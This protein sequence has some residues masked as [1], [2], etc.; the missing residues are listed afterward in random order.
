MKK[1]F[2]KQREI[3]TIIAYFGVV[4]LLVSRRKI[5][6]FLIFKADPAL[7]S[8]FIKNLIETWKINPLLM[9]RAFTLLVQYRHFYDFM[10]GLD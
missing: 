3:I 9:R 4:I 10:M 8:V 5:I 7:R 6:K 2:Q 1:F